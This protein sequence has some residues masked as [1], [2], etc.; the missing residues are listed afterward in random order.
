MAFTNLQLKNTFTGKTRTA[1]VGF[2]WT[3]LFFTW[4]PALIRGDFKWALIQMVLLMCSL[5]LSGLIVPFYYNGIYARGLFNDGFV[6]TGTVENFT[7]TQNS[8]NM[9]IPMEQAAA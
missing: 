2:S 6:V 7:K 1:P 5:G 9:D 4:L 8:I 3:T